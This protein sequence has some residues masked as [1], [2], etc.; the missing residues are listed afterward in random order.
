MLGVREDVDGPHG[1]EDVFAEDV[2]V[3]ARSRVDLKVARRLRQIRLDR[4]LSLLQAATASGVNEGN[5]SRMERG[6]SVLTIDVARKLAVVYKVTLDVLL[7]FD[8]K[9]GVGA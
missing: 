5:L 6:R 8:W 2:L 3:R 9:R 7:D 1:G 4:N